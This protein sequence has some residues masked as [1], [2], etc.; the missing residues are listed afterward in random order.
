V[1]G[2]DGVTGV[3]KRPRQCVKVETG[4]GSKH[5]W[6]MGLSFDWSYGIGDRLYGTLIRGVSSGVLR[7]ET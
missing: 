4:L 3:G 5:F 6:K 1:I 7:L 2:G